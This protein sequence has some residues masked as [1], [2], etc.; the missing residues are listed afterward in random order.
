MIYVI[1]NNL[2]LKY[3]SFEPL[4]CKDIG[5]INFYLWQTFSFFACLIKTNT[6]NTISF[7]LLFQESIT[8]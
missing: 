5:N 3:Q 7:L 2:S 8:L 4:G 1:S 6:K